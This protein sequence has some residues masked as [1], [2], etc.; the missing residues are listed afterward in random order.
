MAQADYYEVEKEIA[1]YG[2]LNQNNLPFPLNLVGCGPTAAINSFV[3]LQNKYPLVY[4]QLLVTNPVVDAQTLAGANYMNTQNP[5]GTLV[6]DFVWGKYLYIEQFAPNRTIYAGEMV[7]QNNWTAQRPKPAWVSENNAYPTWSF[8]Y[9]ELKKCEDVEILLSWSG[10]GHFLTL[11]SFIWNDANNNQTIDFNENAQID[12]IDPCT[13]AQGWSHLWQSYYGAA[14]ETNYNENGSLITM[15][16]SESPVPLPSA[17]LLF[18]SG[19]I[20]LWG[21]RR[22][23]HQ[24]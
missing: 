11:T 22:R 23:F 13:G 10:G 19:I 5:G 1:L 14:L 15:A 6:R 24:N 12:Y 8:M 7:P 16:V 18:G 17:V 20:A 2:N 9:N 3:Y 21:V 4:D